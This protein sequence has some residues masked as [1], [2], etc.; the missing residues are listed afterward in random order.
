MGRG[1][2]TGRRPAGPAGQTAGLERD[3][4][5]DTMRQPGPLLLVLL[6]PLLA[7]AASAAN[8]SPNPSPSQA[9]EAAVTLGRPAG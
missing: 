3:S 8:P 4:T 2:G 5:P 6:L 1:R 7:A 9:V